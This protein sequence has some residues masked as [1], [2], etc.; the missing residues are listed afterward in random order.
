VELS[1]GSGEVPDET[2]GTEELSYL[3]ARRISV[4]WQGELGVS[5]YFQVRVNLENQEISTERF[6][7][8]T[9]MSLSIEQRF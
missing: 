7:G 6:R 3:G 2:L 8:M 9:G 5:R 4:L 1:G